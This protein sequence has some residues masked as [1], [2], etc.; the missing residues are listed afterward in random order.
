VSNLFNLLKRI[1]LLVY[2][3]KYYPYLLGGSKARKLRSIL[4]HAKSLAANAI[5]SAGS[6]SSNHARDCAIACA[7][8]GWQCKL[9]IHDLEDYSINNLFLMKLAGAELIFCKMNEVA[10]KMDSVM[11]EL[12]KENATPYYI[13][14]GGHSVHGTKAFFDAAKHFVDQNPNWQPD[15]VIVPSGTGG[16]QAG[17]HV[18]FAVSSPKTK[19]I[20]ISVAREKKRGLQAVQGAVHEVIKYLNI[21][22]PIDSTPIFLDKWRGE[23]YGKTYPRLIK[24]VGDAAKMGILTDTTYT[25]KALCALCEMISDGE[26]KKNSKVLFWHTGGIMNLMDDKKSLLSLCK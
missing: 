18:G 6:S 16:T 19:V 11:E 21:N 20:G 12:R 8:L 9:V 1:D 24:I 15:F 17:L 23:G 3:E 22:T 13:W 2:E 5:V 10:E 25:G 14:G 26:I 7:Q 4:E